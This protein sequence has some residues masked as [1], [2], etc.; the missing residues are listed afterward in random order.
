MRTCDQVHKRAKTSR[1]SSD[2]NEY[3]LLRNKVTAMNRKARTKYFRNK[4]EENRGKSTAFW[5]T[6]TLHQVLPSKISCT[7]IDKIVVDGKELTS[8]L[9][10]SQ[11]YV[12]CTE[13][14]VAS[15]CARAQIEQSGFRSPGCGLCAVFLG[16][17]LNSDSASLNPGV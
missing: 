2:W 16:R 14:T 11:V 15:K 4:L 3:K 7:D 13:G 6:C 10:C 5:D 8:I 17:T 1:L 12:E 9:Q